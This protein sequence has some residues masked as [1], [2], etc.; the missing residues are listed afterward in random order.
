MGS[1]TQRRRRSNKHARNDIADCTVLYAFDDFLITKLMVALETNAYLEIFL[2]CLP[3]SSQHL[4]NAL[5]I[6]GNPASP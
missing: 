5:P 4:A 2:V 6:D 1:R 3:R